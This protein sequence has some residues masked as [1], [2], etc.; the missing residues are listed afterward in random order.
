ME[1]EIDNTTDMT[2]QKMKDYESLWYSMVKIAEQ[3]RRKDNEDAE[4]RKD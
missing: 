1:E 4:S 3:N 2:K